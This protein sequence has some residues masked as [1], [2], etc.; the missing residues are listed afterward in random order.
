MRDRVRTHLN[1]IRAFA[2]CFGK[3]T[4]DQA[5]GCVGVDI[6]EVSHC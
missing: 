4:G 6:G 1:P 3:V 5:L 2:V